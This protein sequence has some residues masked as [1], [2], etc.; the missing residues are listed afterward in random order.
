MHNKEVFFNHFPFCLLYLHNEADNVYITQQRDAFMQPL[1]QEKSNNY[2]IF[3]KCVFVA[4]GIQHAMHMLHTI[5]CDL[6]GCTIFFHIT[7]SVA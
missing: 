3:Q 5:I 4:L 2:Y 1:L 7:S 6:S